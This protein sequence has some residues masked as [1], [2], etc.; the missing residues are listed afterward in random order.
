MNNW[1]PVI[2]L[3]PNKTHHIIW[4]VLLADKTL[5][6]TKESLNEENV[7]HVLAILPN[8]VNPQIPIEHSIL[9]YSGHNPEIDIT[10]FNK[11]GT[12][13]DNIAQQK[14]RRNVLIFCNNGYQRSIP[15][16]V[17]YLIKFHKN[18][19]PTIEK[20]VHLILSTL[21]R[22]SYL[23]IVDKTVENITLILTSVSRL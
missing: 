16:I 23:S 9:R 18:E 6:L 22:E 12:L 13:I 14:E 7:S 15:F 5:E 20:A 8:D 1:E 19:F 3:P 11:Y 21:E 10:L 2:P 4:N 17:Y